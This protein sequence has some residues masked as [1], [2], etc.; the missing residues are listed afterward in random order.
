MLK[1]LSDV[2]ICDVDG[3]NNAFG[4]PVLS[5]LQGICGED[6]IWNVIEKFSQLKSKDILKFL[7]LGSNDLADLYRKYICDGILR[8]TRCFN[9][10]TLDFSLLFDIYKDFGLSG[11][12]IV[13]AKDLT[14]DERI[15]SVIVDPNYDFDEEINYAL[16]QSAKGATCYIRLFDDLQKTGELNTNF[17]MLPLKY[18][19]NN[20][21]MDKKFCIVGGMCADKE[22]FSLISAY[23]GKLIICPYE[24]SSLGK[25]FVNVVAMRNSGA[26][27]EIASPLENDIKK[28]VDFLSVMTKGLLS[29]TDE[30]S[31]DEVLQMCLSCDGKIDFKC[32]YEDLEQRCEKIK[33][34][35]KEINYADC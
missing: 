19:E 8:G 27:I 3:F 16:E 23:G 32:D 11:E 14:N 13:R 18:I 12:I 7:N 6:K 28:E 1:R 30:I 24:Q 34:K 26:E 21:L 17:N 10:V 33:Q 31:K 35:L 2:K 15:A 4:T 29:S 5:F 22:D 9:I 25:G 20:G